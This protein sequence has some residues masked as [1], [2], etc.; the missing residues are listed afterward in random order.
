MGNDV[1]DLEEVLTIR[2]ERILV[3]G[4]IVLQI[5]VTDEALRLIVVD[6]EDKEGCLDDHLY[7]DGVHTPSV[8]PMLGLAARGAAVFFAG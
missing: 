7:G 3:E 6:R 2:G 8:V 1:V 4:E 5:D